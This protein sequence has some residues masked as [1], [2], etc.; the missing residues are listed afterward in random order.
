MVQA[1]PCLTGE[2]GRPETCPPK[3]LSTLQY[4]GDFSLAQYVLLSK[5]LM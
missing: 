5:T 1:G 4:A 2:A 3:Y